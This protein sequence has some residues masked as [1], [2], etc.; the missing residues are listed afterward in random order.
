MSLSLLF[1]E[2]TACLVRLIWTVLEMGG[3]WLYSCCFVGCYFQHLFNI[4]RSILVQLPSSFFSIRLISIYI[5]YLYSSS[6]TTIYIYIY[7]SQEHVYKWEC[8]K[9]RDSNTLDSFSLIPLVEQTQPF[10]TCVTSK[11]KR[12]YR[13]SSDRTPTGFNSFWLQ[14]DCWW[15]KDETLNF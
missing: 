4:A 14:I 11:V 9:I 13:Y 2:C 1:W 3:R 8:Q 7:I 5:V 15:E 12:L 6:D 10:N